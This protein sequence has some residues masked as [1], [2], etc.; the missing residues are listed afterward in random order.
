MGGFPVKTM[1]P[2]T[3]DAAPAT[4]GKLNIATSPAANHNLFP[5]PRMLSSLVIANLI[6]DAG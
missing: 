6:L 5:A 3:V 4:S 2:E 1:V